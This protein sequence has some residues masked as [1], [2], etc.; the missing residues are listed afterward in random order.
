MQDRSQATFIRAWHLL[1]VRTLAV[2]Q[3]QRKLDLTGF[4]GHKTVHF[5]LL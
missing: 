2:G 4:T 1:E 5:A 3:C